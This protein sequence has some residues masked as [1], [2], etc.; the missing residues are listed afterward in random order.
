ML[1]FQFFQRQSTGNDL[2]TPK[3][4]SELKM[5]DYFDFYRRVILHILYP[6]LI[7]YKYGYWKLEQKIKKVVINKTK[8]YVWRDPKTS[9]EVP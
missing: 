9:S 4:P 6:Y 2:G 1:H 7:P 3:L 5:S 8:L